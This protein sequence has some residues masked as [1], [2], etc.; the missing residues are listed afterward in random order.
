MEAL[1]IPLQLLPPIICCCNVH[2]SSDAS[3]HLNLPPSVPVPA[4]VFVLLPPAPPIWERLSF[5]AEFADVS[6]KKATFAPSR[7]GPGSCVSLNGSAA[8]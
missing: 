5:H 4:L 6:E 7:R 1:I 3:T 2:T 8:G